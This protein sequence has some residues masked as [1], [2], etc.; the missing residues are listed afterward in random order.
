M[1]GAG[2]R[3]RTSRASRPTDP[4]PDADDIDVAEDANSLLDVLALGLVRLARQGD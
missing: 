1:P 3:S 2:T 4:N